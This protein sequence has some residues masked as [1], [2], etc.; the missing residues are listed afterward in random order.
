MNRLTLLTLAAVTAACAGNAPPVTVFGSPGDVLALAG[1]W[2][3]EYRSTETGR[4]GSIWFKLEAGRDTAYGDVLMVPKETG[5]AQTEPRAQRDLQSIPQILSI[6]FVR[7]T[8]RII[9]GTLDPYPSPD[10]ECLL[11]TVFRGELN[12]DRIEGEFL[13]RHSD[14]EMAPQAGKFW[15][16]RVSRT[17]TP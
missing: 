4:S 2:E 14:Q 9:S 3:G 5:I 6:R 8:G 12:G 16:K 11:Y 17:P 10:C 13:I 7:A 1:Q 15:A